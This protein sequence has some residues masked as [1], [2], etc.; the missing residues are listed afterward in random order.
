MKDVT[1][2]FQACFLIQIQ[3]LDNQCFL[4]VSLAWPVG[5]SLLRS[6]P[7]AGS[8][9]RR[10]QAGPQMLPGGQ[11][12]PPWVFRTQ[13]LPIGRNRTS[14]TLPQHGRRENKVDFASKAGLFP[15]GF[16]LCLV[17]RGVFQS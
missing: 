13:E 4:Q 3:E 2:S 15:K 11:C 14:R 7:P 9:S 8:A 5:K 1:F 17:W 6:Q 16:L 12:S 10:Q